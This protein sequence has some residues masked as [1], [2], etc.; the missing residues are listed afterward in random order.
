MKKLTRLAATIASVAL[1]GAAACEKQGGGDAQGGGTEG[2]PQTDAQ[3]QGGAT[4]GSG[5]G[6]AETAGSPGVTPGGAAATPAD[7]AT[8]V[9]TPASAGVPVPQQQP[10]SGGNATISTPSGNGTP[11]QAGGTATGRP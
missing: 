9:P 2:M 3:L 7:S 1:V 4:S 5:A 10:G 11:P 8:G 6:P